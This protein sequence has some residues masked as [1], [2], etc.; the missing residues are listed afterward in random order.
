MQVLKPATGFLIDHELISVNNPRRLILRTWASPT[1]MRVTVLRHPL[2]DINLTQLIHTRNTTQSV[3]EPSDQPLIQDPLHH[4]I[5][6]LRRDLTK[7]IPRGR[8]PIN[9]R[10]KR[11]LQVL[12][13]IP[14]SVDHRL[15]VGLVN[16]P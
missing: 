2:R 6:G 5:H 12:N 7:L 14:E 1:T 16:G 15:N 3:I 8:N 11:I 9:S 10:L 4:E 13:D